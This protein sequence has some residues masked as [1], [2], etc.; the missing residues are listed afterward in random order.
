METV[1]WLIS[2]PYIRILIF[3]L[4]S[5]FIF[6]ISILLLPLNMIYYRFHLLLAVIIPSI[7]IEKIRAGSNSFAFGLNFD[8]ITLK[9][10]TSGLL[11]A[12]VSV[13]IIFIS[14]LLFINN[15]IINENAFNIILELAFDSLLVSFIEEIFFRGIIFQA[16]S[17][18]IKPF[19]SIIISSIIFSLYHF[20]NPGFSVMAFINIFIAGLIFGIMYYIT[21][22]LWMPIAYHFCWNFLTGS[23]IDTPVSGLIYKIPLHFELSIPKNTLG[24]FIQNHFGLLF[25]KDFGIEEGLI[26]TF[27]LL[28]SLFLTFKYA[29]LSPFQS[30]LIFK[31]NYEESKLKSNI[32]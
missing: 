1:R 24:N 22:N 25:G 29:S 31:R 13:N 14:K 9:N 30:A 17:D 6:E 15:I 5:Y 26:A 10:F 23:F 20:L 12:L 4:F 16:L 3:L 18:L 7:V 21:K 27:V 2:K 11:I 19:M 32:M 8:R 28:L